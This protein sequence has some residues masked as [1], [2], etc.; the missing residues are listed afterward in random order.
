MFNHQPDTCKTD[1]EKIINK[2]DLKECQNFINT[3]R[4][5]RHLKTM[6]GQ[7]QKL[8]WLCHGNSSKRGG[9]SNTHGDHTCTTTDIAGVSPINN[10]TNTNKWV[11]NISGKPLTEAQ[12]KLLAH[13]PNHA[14][15]PRSPPIT[16]YVAAIEQVSS[17][18]QQGQAEELMEGSNPSL[19]KH[20]VPPT[21]TR[22]K[23]RP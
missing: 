19:R 23:W 13:R 4:D 1:L 3:R 21:S 15:V 10:N 2:E 7:K 14:V 17:K 22:K 5:A 11:I 8:E 6:D 12:E 20:T 16:E 9:H 18:L